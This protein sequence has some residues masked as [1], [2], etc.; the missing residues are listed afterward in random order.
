MK[1]SELKRIIRE[2]INE[3]QTDS[4]YIKLKG[5]IFDTSLPIEFKG[6]WFRIIDIKQDKDQYV[7]YFKI[8]SQDKEVSVDKSLA[9]RGSRPDL[10]FT[11]GKFG[12]PMEF[13]RMFIEWKKQR[14]SIKSVIKNK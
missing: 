10:D 2:C 9:I 6:K 12:P 8:N 13:S 4:F 11:I 5:E 7:I 1:K 3:S 14:G